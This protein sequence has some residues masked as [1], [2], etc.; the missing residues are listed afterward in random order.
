M[1]MGIWQTFLLLLIVSS[2]VLPLIAIINIVRS[3]F[4][5][6]NS[7]LIWVLIVLFLPIMGSLVYFVVG[8][9]Q[10]KDET[11]SMDY[12]SK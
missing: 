2:F 12:Y 11:E 9:S 6:N 10:K 7:K 1:S 4:K 3:E 8:P 5:E